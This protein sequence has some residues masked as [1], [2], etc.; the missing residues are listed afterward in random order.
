MGAGDGSTSVLELDV[1]N[2]NNLWCFDVLMILKL[3]F[4]CKVIQEGLVNNSKHDRNNASDMFE[5]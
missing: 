3:I 4:H 2:R 1:S 5:R